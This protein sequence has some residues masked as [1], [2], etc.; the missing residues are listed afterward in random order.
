MILQGNAALRGNQVN[1]A[2]IA[3]RPQLTLRHHRHQ[4]R[5]RDNPR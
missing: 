5:R 1:R 2:G 3:A 4:G